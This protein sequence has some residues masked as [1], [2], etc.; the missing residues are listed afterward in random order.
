VINALGYAHD[1]GLVHRDVKGGNILID[2]QK[3]PRLT[4][5]GIAG[6]FKSGHNALQITSG[7]SLFCMSPQQLDGRRPSPSDDIYALGVLLYELFTGY[8]PFYPDISR[9]KILHEI[10]AAVNQRL[11][12]TA[13]DAYVPRSLETL[14]E[15]MLAKMPA[16]RPT[17]MQEI[18]NRLLRILNPQA[19]QILPP[20]VMATGPVEDE[21]ALNRAEIITPV[22]VTPRAARKELPLSAH[23][24]LVKSLTLAITFVFLVAAGLWLWQ[25]LA[26]RPPGQPQAKKTV[27]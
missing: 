11:G 24:N 2:R 17:S 23:S 20:D 25:Y 15:Q 21:S 19:D 18:D 12:Q 5:F 13:A 9:D 8:P 16:E 26:S 14:I 10:P 1:L 22:S 7:G 6:V 27:S 3:T 4:D